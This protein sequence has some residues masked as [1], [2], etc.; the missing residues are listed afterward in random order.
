M[1]RRRPMSALLAS[2]DVLTDNQHHPLRGVALAVLG[3]TAAN[4]LVGE[5]ERVG[6]GTDNAVR[7]L[8]LAFE[9]EL[10]RIEQGEK[11]QPFSWRIS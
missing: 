11:V 3:E 9:D 6:I 1:S 8:R 10:N 7:Y 2:V 5:A 4:A